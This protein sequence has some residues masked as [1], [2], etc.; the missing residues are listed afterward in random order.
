MVACKAGWH[1]RVAAIGGVDR[2][3]G[4]GRGALVIPGG[5]RTSDHGHH[6]QC[7]TVRPLDARLLELAPLGDGIVTRGV[8]IDLPSA[9]VRPEDI[10]AW[11]RETGVTLE[12][13][14]ALLLRT[15]GV[16]GFYNA[17]M[18]FIRERD[19]AMVIAD[20][21]LHAGRARDAADRWCGP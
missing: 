15:G 6:R 5:D 14:D 2:D 11:E 3:P 1:E 20:A 16:G 21:C 17:V 8:L 18:P 10:E 9:R 13:G 7:R 4:F 12:P 19:L